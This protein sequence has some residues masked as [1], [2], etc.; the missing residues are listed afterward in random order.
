V[1]EFTIRRKLIKKAW[2]LSEKPGLQRKEFVKTE[3]VTLFSCT[4]AE[5]NL[6]SRTATKISTNKY[7]SQVFF[8]N[9]LFAI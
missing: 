4:S 2:K 1:A 5:L 9:N 3:F 7:K 6:S 8:K